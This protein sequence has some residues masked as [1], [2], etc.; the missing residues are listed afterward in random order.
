MLAV[1][2]AGLSLEMIQSQNVFLS[3]VPYLSVSLLIS[4]MIEQK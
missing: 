1:V 4:K 2:N 3:S